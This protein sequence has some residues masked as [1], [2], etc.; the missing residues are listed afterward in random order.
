MRNINVCYTTKEELESFIDRN[1]IGNSSSLLI[2]IFSASDQETFIRN[3]LS[4]ITA[5]LPDAVIIGSSTDGGI[6][7]GRVVSQSTILSFTQ[8]ENTTL[9]AAGVEHTD[10]GYESGRALAKALVG[11][12]TKLLI[13]FSDGVHTNGEAFLAGIDA[14]DASVPV[15]GGHAGDNNLFTKTMVFTKEHLFTKGSVAVTLNSRHLHLHTDYSFN[16]HPIG[17]EFTITK[18][19]KNRVYT[20]DNTSAANLYAYYLGE[21]VANGLPGI[22]IEFPL[23]V[24]RNGIDVARAVM[25]KVDDGSLIVAGSLYTGEKVRFGFGDSR[26]IMHASQKIIESTLKKPSEAI[27]VYSCAARKYFMGDE[28]E[29]EIMPLQSIAPV[30]GFFTHGEYFTSRKK[31][32]LNQTMAIVS[33]SE[34][35]N[36][37]RLKEKI[38]PLTLKSVENTSIHA[39]SRFIHVTTEEMQKQ[40]DILKE[41]NRLNKKLKERM[42]LA[43]VGSKT[44]VLDWDLKENALYISPRWK[45]MLGYSDEELPNTIDV[46]KERVHQADKKK[47]FV[48]MNKYQKEKIRYFENIHRLKHRNG[49]WIWILGRAQILYDQHGNAVRMIGT[50]TDITEEKELQLKYAHQAQ[51]IE[52][53]HDSVIATDLDGYITSWNKGSQLLLGYSAEEMIGQHVKLLYLKEDYDFVKKNFAQLLQRGEQ[54]TEIR[55]IKKSREII[56]ADLSLSLL[57]DENEKVIGTIGYVQ[58]IT[59]HKKIQE[60]LDE[61]KEILRYQAQHDAMTGLPNRVLFF[62]RLEQGIEKS[63]RQKVGLALFFIDLDKF[64]HINDSLGHAIGD[65]VLKLISQ[66]LKATI[67]REDTLARLSGDEF[68]VIME[69]VIH[70]EDASLLAEKILQVLA[71]PMY[72]DE[73]TLY[74][75]GS[76]GISL[77]PKDTDNAQNL[78]KFADTAMYKAKEEGRNNYQFYSYE[79]TEFALER[80][81]MKTSLRQAIEKNEFTIHYQPQIN[82]YG[83]HLVGLEALVRWQHP[84]KGFLYPNEF[85]AL[86]E[87]TGVII[88]IDKWV[89]QAAMIQVA[90]WYKEGLEPGVLAL[91]LSIKQFERSDFLQELQEIMELNGFRAEWLELEITEGQMMKKPEEVIAKL[92]E[93]TALGIGISIDDF[94]TGYSSLSLLKR[95]PINRLKIDRSF[96]RD[97]PGNEEDVAIVKAIIALAGSLKLNLIAEGVETGAQKRFLVDNGCLHI[98]GHYYSQALSAEKMKALLVKNSTKLTGVKAET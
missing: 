42:E 74:V 66:R 94:G 41:S 48:L 68:T 33:L 39:L 85:I 14:V 65:R 23:I 10:N 16:W 75:S 56:F 45:E 73:H 35:D 90:Q 63:K 37:S 82:V 4:E 36:L 40:T 87:E 53:I 50:H 92:K 91:N 49:Q 22:G 59:E 44:S 11:D 72:I 77:Y 27:F 83:N 95:L 60:A 89:M 88:E 13:A 18:A 97:V 52:Q 19:E 26:A 78:L 5:L 98:Q 57:K 79:M 3:L 30:S 29:S 6:I 64:K 47:L 71:E 58:D 80:M 51:I 20:I 15:A 1:R 32:L 55:L 25:M 81:E 31:Q 54:K 62:D 24:R 96:I 34:S 86:A 9:K 38:E 84:E 28:I 7:N 8:F 43:L 17:N 21:E 76:I 2:Q 46:W 69:E 93:I 67:R 12:D 61:Q 70:E